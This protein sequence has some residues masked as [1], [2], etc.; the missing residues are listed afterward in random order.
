VISE[1]TWV[2]RGAGAPLDPPVDSPL[3]GVTAAEARARGWYLLPGRAHS[4]GH[5]LR[6][7]CLY[8]SIK[9]RGTDSMA[10]GSDSATAGSAASQEEG[11]C[12]RH[13][14]ERGGSCLEFVCGI[15]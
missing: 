9:A 4:G 11:I 5:Q 3:G 2:I 7:L 14:G 15:Y 12:H 6:R 1:E 13:G 8:R 10:A